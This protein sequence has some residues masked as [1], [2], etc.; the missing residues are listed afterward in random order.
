MDILSSCFC[1]RKQYLSA[2]WF[3]KVIWLV[4]RKTESQ[5]LIVTQQD[6]DPEKTESFSSLYSWEAK[7]KEKRK[8]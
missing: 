6:Q 3:I 8:D 7:E 4:S 5:V 1:I 2:E